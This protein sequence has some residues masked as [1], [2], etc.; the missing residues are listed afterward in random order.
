MKER[1]QK[2]IATA[3]DEAIARMRSARSATNEV[4]DKIATGATGTALSTLFD[5]NVAMHDAA[6][7]A[8]KALEASIRDA[9][10][11]SI[12]PASELMLKKV[13]AAR[14]ASETLKTTASPSQVQAK[15]ASDADD[16]AVTQL[17]DTKAAFQTADEL[18]EREHL[19]LF[20]WLQSL[21]PSDSLRMLVSVGILAIGYY[22]T[23]LIADGLPARGR[24]LQDLAIIENA[25]GLITFLLGLSTIAI[26]LM[27]VIGALLGTDNEE[28]KEK[29]FNR[30]KEVLAILVGIFGTI[31]GFYFGSD[32]ATVKA[33]AI[34]LQNAGLKLSPLA[35]ARSADGSN[36]TL[37]ANVSGGLPPYTY[38]IAFD[39][40]SIPSIT[41]RTSVDGQISE[42]IT[43]VPP[44]KT[45]SFT[46][47]AADSSITNLVS[48]QYSDKGR[49]I[50]K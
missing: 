32:K 9:G 28:A 14:T 33:A 3:A 2:A 41:N 5:R 8:A 47:T 17:V 23:R 15:A 22:L 13:G 21:S 19:P 43:N 42:A 18:K 6:L 26:A 40:T 35:L 38:S 31:L 1:I 16:E 4:A 29:N 27:L 48:Q 24:L 30:A 11:T 49:N 12:T 20:G 36:T 50:S 45:I 39:D 7:S 34:M 37:A 25:R 44:S 10:V 46:L